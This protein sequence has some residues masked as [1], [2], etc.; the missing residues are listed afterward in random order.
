MQEILYLV[1]TAP[2]VYGIET[3]CGE[4][5]VDIISVATA[6]TVYGIETQF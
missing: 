1:A 6:P 4:E 2:T 3:K 5:E